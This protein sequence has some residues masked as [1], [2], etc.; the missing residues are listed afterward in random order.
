MQAYAKIFE[1]DNMRLLLKPT[2]M[3]ETRDFASNNVDS[4]MKRG[5]RLA[6]N[7]DLT[8]LQGRKEDVDRGIIEAVQQ[9]RELNNLLI[10]PPSFCAWF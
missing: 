8:P 5:F 10:M 2:G 4:Y 7:V 9:S 1:R 6:P 3:G